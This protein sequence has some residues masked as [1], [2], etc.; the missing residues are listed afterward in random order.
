MQGYIVVWCPHG[1][2]NMI[3][4]CPQMG[5]NE[6]WRIFSSKDAFLYERRKS[7][8][9][10][11]LPSHIRFVRMSHC[12]KMWCLMQCFSIWEGGGNKWEGKKYEYNLVFF[13][14]SF[15]TYI[16]RPFCRNWLIYRTQMESYLCCGLKWHSRV[17]SKWHLN[18]I[19]SQ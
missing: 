7:S 8:E 11:E 9:L 15:Q 10:L 14:K 13:L 18:F 12:G 16:T 1:V 17:S 6:K 5:H 4:H 19:E 3:S 2:H